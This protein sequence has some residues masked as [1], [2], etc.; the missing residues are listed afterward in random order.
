MKQVLARRGG[1]VV[2]DVPA[3]A[4]GPRSIL[5]RVHYSCV[6]AGT[7]LTGVELSGMPLYRRALKQ[8]H[9]A[10]K[11]LELARDQGFARTYGRIA[12]RLSAGV[13]IGYSAAGVVVAIGEQVSGFAVGDRVA[14]AGAKLANHAE[15]ISVPVNLAA[16]VPDG[17]A[18]DEAATCTLGAIALQGVRR[19]E[20]TLGETIGVVG[21]GVL[22]Q[23]TVQ[24]L[25][26]HGA[27]VLA[28]D[29][30]PH[31][32]EQALAGGANWV[33]APDEPLAEAARRVSEGFGLDA[34]I[35]TAASS[36][37]SVVAQAFRA[38]R[39]R[40]RVVVVGDVGLAL[41]RQDMYEKELELRMST[42]YGPGRYDPVYEDEG[43][44][45]PYGHVRW[46]EGRNL[47]EYL[48]LLGERAVRLDHLPAERYPV[49]EAPQAYEALSRD[50]RRP[51]LVV[52]EFEQDGPRPL[53]RTLPL[54]RRATGSGRIK[55]GLVGAGSFAE[56]TIVPNLSRL[57]ADVE[58][59][60]VMSRNG[61]SAKYLATLGDAAYATTDLDVLLADPEIDLIVVATRHDLHASLVLAALEA[62]KS[63]FV[64]KPLALDPE[65]LDQIEARY[66]A[67]AGAPLLMTGFNRRFS[68]AARQLAAVLAGRT[69]PLMIDYR[70]NAGY[71]PLDHWVHGPEG[72]GRNIGEACHIYDLFGALVGEPLEHVTAA[73]I[74]PSARLAAND[75]FTATLS[76]RDGSICTLTYT[77][78]GAKG[79][80]KEQMTVYADGSVIT[81]DDY[82]SLR[83]S[84]RRRPL[85]WS[86][87]IDKGHR[88]EFEALA[89][90]VAH[91]GPWPIPLEEQLQAT[92]VSFEV[93]ALIRAAGAPRRQ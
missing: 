1:V 7:E 5:V 23:L 51:T 63:V 46:T 53:G 16:R 83:R 71:L 69:A 35:L 92:R 91:G 10:R 15:I 28:S 26:A 76:F 89:R 65:E 90:C 2:E 55:A 49:D 39:R 72:G 36:S 18:L 27:R 54:T 78:L 13:P 8:P 86:R 79:H 70:M 62:G 41:E 24:L 14:C 66:R 84:G 21:L 56:G 77:A 45:Y 93:E 19:A 68:P 58:L 38:C 40:G 50:E 52:L 32:G 73:A 30:D 11:A 82:R 88:A 81:L 80:P 33:A 29:L 74:R 42:S 31:R 67:D 4:V 60:G 3:P 64:E 48:R 85:W 25:R 44:D 17:L 37:S 20:P 43:H 22:G 9:H 87:S 12:N 34:V 61:L 6:S 47:H 75:N 59:R 57:A